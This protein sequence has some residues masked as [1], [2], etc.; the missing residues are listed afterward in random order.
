M[1]VV[2]GILWGLMV[3]WIGV[4]IW[5]GT[6]VAPELFAWHLSWPL[7]FSM[8]GIFVLTEGIEKLA[9]R[10]SK[11]SLR[12]GWPIFWGLVFIA[13]GL[14]IWFSKLGLIPGFGTIWPFIFVVIGLAII[15]NVIAKTVRKPRRVNVIIDKLEDGEIDVDAAADEIRRTRRNT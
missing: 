6:S 2:R 11:G 5:L 8:V 1:R 14:V 13:L 3:A 15:I 4:W 10:S 7:I 12:G 9:R